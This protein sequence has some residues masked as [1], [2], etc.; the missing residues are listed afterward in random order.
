MSNPFGVPGISVR[1]AAALRGG[2]D[3][4]ILLDVREPHEL[5]RAN[6]GESITAVPLSELA[7][8]QLAALPA[9]IADNKEAHVVVLCHHGGRSAQVVAWLRQQGWT[10]VFNM[11][12]G[13]D[14][15]ALQIDP[16]V[17]RY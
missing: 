6:L 14:A 5:Q 9:T 15:Y 4:V 3:D 17:G 16:S 2:K 12:G 1:E 13:I 10:S 7:S 8:K 11:D